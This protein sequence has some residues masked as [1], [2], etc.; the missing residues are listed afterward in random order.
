ML[1]TLRSTTARKPRKG[2]CEAPPESNLPLTQVRVFTYTNNNFNN[3]ICMKVQL[4]TF[5][6]TL[7]SLMQNSDLKARMFFF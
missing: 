6:S 7:N 4:C 2:N 5:P 3:N 1:L